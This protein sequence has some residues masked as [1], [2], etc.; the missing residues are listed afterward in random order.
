VPAAA[1][2][3]FCEL[4]KAG[5]DRLVN[6]FQLVSEVLTEAARLRL[7]LTVTVD[8]SMVSAQNIAHRLPGSR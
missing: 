5:G 3:R 4:L 1:V 6:A 2:V 7:T 8:W